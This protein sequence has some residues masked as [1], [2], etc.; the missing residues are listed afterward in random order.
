MGEEGVR[1]W[2]GTRRKWKYK[3]V[4]DEGTEGGTYSNEN[5]WKDE[6]KRKNIGMQVG[7]EQ[8]CEMDKKIERGLRGYGWDLEKNDK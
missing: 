7:G 3:E 6:A 8:K 4:K 5:N 1:T 2:M